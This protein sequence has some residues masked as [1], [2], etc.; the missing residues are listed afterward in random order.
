[1][2]NV[3]YGLIASVTI[4]LMSMPVGTVAS[5]LLLNYQGQ[6]TDTAGGSADRHVYDDL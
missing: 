6:L 5:P 1:M 2:R 3:T 4:G